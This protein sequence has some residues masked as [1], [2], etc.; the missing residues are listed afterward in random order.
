MNSEVV[1]SPGMTLPFSHLSLDLLLVC[2]LI[3]S[4][5]N[6]P[7]W[8]QHCDGMATNWQQLHR[9]LQVNI[10]LDNIT[11]TYTHRHVIPARSG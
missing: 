4:D 2:S 5:Y 6:T 3:L 11:H 10:H 7:T 1:L 8:Q 9:F